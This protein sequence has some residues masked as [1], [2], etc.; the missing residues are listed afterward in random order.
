MLKRL[1]I[2]EMHEIAR[3]K[4]G[5]CLSHNYLNC[6]TKLQWQC[7]EGHIW[8]TEPNAI[9][10]RNTWCLLC[11]NK[12]IAEGR[13]ATIE[14]MQELAKKYNGWCLSTEYVGKD[15]HLDWKCSEGHTWSASPNNVKRGTWCPICNGG[16]SNSQDFYLK[17]CQKLADER[18][19]K[20]LS[21]IYINDRT[22]LQWQCKYGHIW[23]AVPSSIKNNE[24]WCPQCNISQ[25]ESKGEK[26]CRI[27]LENIFQKEFK[28]SK[29]NWLKT[30]GNWQLELDGYNE[31]MG[32]AFEYNGPQHYE[33][34]PF[35]HHSR[36]RFTQRKKLDKIKKHLCELHNIKLIT[37]SQQH[38][39]E[40]IPDR[41]L[42]NCDELRCSLPDPISFVYPTELDML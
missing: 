14:Q 10:N 22:K 11:A 39:F 33:Y 29:P 31:E 24:S 5:K 42:Y 19:G 9:K 4:G 28:K 41:L 25:T 15:I 32:L 34:I 21:S 6:H 26:I 27:I 2:E 7:K 36:K 40:D 38:D 18:K 12:K 35:F 17:Q 8:E 23:W 1:T 13:K 37:V 16:G 20:C 3:N 30:N